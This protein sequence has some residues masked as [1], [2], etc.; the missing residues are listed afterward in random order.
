MPTHLPPNRI[1]YTT[2]GDVGQL[3]VDGIDLSAHV[4]APVRIE[5]VSDGRHAPR[6]TVTVRFPT[7]NLGTTLDRAGLH[8]DLS[9]EQHAALVLAGWTPPAPTGREEGR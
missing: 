4:L 1:T 2:D 3:V 8:V 5:T 9:E 6:T 7:D